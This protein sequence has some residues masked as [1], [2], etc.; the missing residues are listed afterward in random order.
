MALPG[1]AQAQMLAR[2]LA[3]IHRKYTPRSVAVLGCAGGNGFGD[4]PPAITRRV[5]G[6]DLN[7]DYVA[8]ARE[9]YEGRFQNLELY[10]ADVQKDLPAFTPVDLVFAALILEYV[11]IDVVIARTRSMLA[12]HGKLV[13]VV[14][15]P[16]STTAKVT[17]SPFASLQALGA[18]MRLVPPQAV[19]RSAQAHGYVQLESSAVS[20]AGGKRFQVQVFALAAPP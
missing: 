13:T 14:Q 8:K 16:G 18:V 2:I 20:S 6:V 5:V 17:P 4:I 12:T 15:M 1:I 7:P 3:E 10:V 19:R 9:R 11:D